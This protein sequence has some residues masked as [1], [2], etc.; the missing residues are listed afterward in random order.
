MDSTN[1]DTFVGPFDKLLA[2]VRIE[3]GMSWADE[4]ERAEK[5]EN[6][7]DQSLRLKDKSVYYYHNEPN[8]V[9]NTRNVRRTLDINEYK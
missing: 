6:Q 2:S 7:T 1:T 5:E 4:V 3:P 9:Q 8:V